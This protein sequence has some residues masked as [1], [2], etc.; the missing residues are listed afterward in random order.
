M[1]ILDTIYWNLDNNIVIYTNLSPALDL[2][3]KEKDKFL[4]KNYATVY[5]I[6]IIYNSKSISY[7]IKSEYRIILI[8]GIK[9]STFLKGKKDNYIIYNS[10]LQYIMKYYK[11]KSKL[12]L[13]KIKYWIIYS[14]K[15]SSHYKY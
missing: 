7:N 12:D 14:N 5:I 6:N 8:K 11:E 9:S 3:G 13:L 15:C 4:N 10:F 2:K 1:L